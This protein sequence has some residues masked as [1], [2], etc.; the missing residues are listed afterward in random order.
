MLMADPCLL[1]LS[2][3]NAIPR[4]THNNVKVHAKDTN[5]GIVSCTEVNVLL[6]PKT[7]VARL[8]KVAPTE[9]VLLHLETTL[10]NFLG[11]RPTDRDMDGNLFV[12]PNSELADGVAGLGCHWCLAR[13]LFEDFGCS[14]QTITGLANGYVDDELFNAEIPHGI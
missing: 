1:N 4:A 8:G 11:F 9:F 6:N 3:R 7:K 2:L 14:G 13:E 12:A 5:R 10:E